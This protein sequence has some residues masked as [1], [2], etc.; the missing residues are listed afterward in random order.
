MPEGFLLGCLI[1][2]LIGIGLSLSACAVLACAPAPAA[3]G[4][5]LADFV[6]VATALG[7]AEVQLL[8]FAGALKIS[9]VLSLAAGGGALAGFLLPGARARA[10]ELIADFAAALYVAGK[11]APLLAAGVLGLVL[12]ARGFSIPE[13][14]WDGL[15]YHLTYPAH[16]LEAGAFGRFD[17]GGVWEQYESFPKGGEALFFLAMLPFHA[18]YFVHWV[19]L[20]LWLATGG[21]VRAAALRLGQTAR[22][23]DVCAAIVLGCPALAAYVTPAYVEVPTTFALCAALAAALRVLI[24]RETSA[25][26]ALGLALGLA[27]AIKIT[28]LAY[29]PLGGLVVLGAMRTQAPRACLR[30]ATHGALLGAALALP[31]Y[32]HS[33]VQCGNPLYPAS[34][35]GATEGPAAGSLENAWAVRESSVFAQAAWGDVIEFLARAPWRVPY[36]LGPG[37]L[38]LAVLPASAALWPVAVVLHR[39]RADQASRPPQLTA[40]VL[41][42]LLALAVTVIYGLSPWNGLFREANTRFLMPAVLAALLSVAASATQLPRWVGIALATIGSATVL[43]AL[44]SARFVRL[45]GQSAIAALAVVMLAAAFVVAARAAVTERGQRVRTIV[46]AAVMTLLA[47]AAL[48]YGVHARDTRRPH[49]YAQEF[50]LH[51][52][53]LSAELWTFVDALPPSRIAFSVGGVNS[54]EGWFFYPLFGAQLQHSVRYI[55]IETHDEPA[56]QRRGLVRDAPDEQRWRER[57]VAAKTQYVVLAGQPIERGWIERAPNVFRRVFDAENSSVYRVSTD[58]AK[59]R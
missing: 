47:V 2:V 17:A 48:A 34:L 59:S 49:A 26:A 30:F 46:T 7:V 38:F 45:N 44:A 23:A 56:C 8:G 13:L 20:P 22:A 50:D 12:A 14:S 51:P 6:L 10:R 27:A 29:L 16:W 57:L 40:A 37:W 24:A 41:L 1:A 19:N 35:P 43:A 4:E 28:A 53:A 54:T 42:W 21:C 52:V 5:R 31:W 39:R 15:T 32:V 55:D 3:R 9:A 33:A 18:D 25:L 36:P 11:S 58:A